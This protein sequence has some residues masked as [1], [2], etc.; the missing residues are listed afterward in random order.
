MLLPSK[1][2]ASPKRRRASPS[3]TMAT[4]GAPGS[5]SVAVKL[6]PTIGIAPSTLK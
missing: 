5:S 3:L 1:A 2:R 6:R 4:R